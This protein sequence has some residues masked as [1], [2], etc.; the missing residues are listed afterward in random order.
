MAGKVADELTNG[1]NKIFE[2]F[3]LPFFCYNMKSIIQLR[4]SGFF[5]VDLTR[6]DALPEVLHRRENAAKYQILEALE[7]INTL[8]SIRMYTSLMHDDKE[9]I[10]KT[11]ESFENICNKLTQ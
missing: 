1:L 8:Q 11:L 5:T 7:G 4:M 9:L 6:P 10:K 2:D 3:K